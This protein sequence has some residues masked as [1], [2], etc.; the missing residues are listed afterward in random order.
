M[1]AVNVCA[2][3]IDGVWLVELEPSVDERGSFTRTFDRDVFAEHGLDPRIAQCSTSFNRRAG[4][5]RGMHHQIGTHAEGKLV[6]CSRGRIFDVVVDLRPDSATHKQWVGFELS[7]DG[8][9]SV[10][11]PEG[12]AH[13]FQTLEDE[14]EVQYQ[15]TTPY[16]PDHYRGVRWDDPAFAIDWPQPPAGGRTMSDRDRSFADYVV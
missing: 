3:K 14:S 4:T 16:A 1:V 5:L 9:R 13:G 10:F 7:V 6:R 2:T 11:V 15:M 12:C 8:A